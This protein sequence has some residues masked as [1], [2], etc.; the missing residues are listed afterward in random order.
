MSVQRIKS[1]QDTSHSLCMC[2]TVDTR[3]SRKLDTSGKLLH[4]QHLSTQSCSVC[5]LKTGAFKEH[6][7][8][9]RFIK[10][11]SLSTVMF[12]PPLQVPTSLFWTITLSEQS[13]HFCLFVC[14]YIYFPFLGNMSGKFSQMVALFQGNLAPK[15][16]FAIAVRILCDLDEVTS[17]LCSS[18]SICKMEINAFPYLLRA[19]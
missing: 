14:F 13:L 17:S 11:I 19:C 16:E 7:Y 3:I 12:W 18:A 5:V 9:A 1:F 2:H 8:F 6:L 4:V 15:A 10:L